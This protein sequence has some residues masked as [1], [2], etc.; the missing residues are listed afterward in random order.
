VSARRSS[1]PRRSIDPDRAHAWRLERQLLGPRR[2]DGPEAVAHALVGVQAQVTSSAALSIALRSGGP[3]ARRGR[4]G[5]V[6]AALRDRRLVRSWAMRSTLHL[7]A[8]EDVPIVAAALGNPERWRRPK[9]L[10]WL[11]MTEPELEACMETID[12]VLDDGRPRTRA[13]LSAEVGDRLGP[14]AARFLLGSWGAALKFASDRSYLV[15]SSADEAGVRFVKAAH[16]VPWR[17][18][19]QGDAMAVIIERYLAAYGPATF[20]ELTRWWG[21]A[22]QAELRPILESLGDRVS[23]VDVDGVPA[24]LRTVD[25]E[26]LEATRPTRGRI[27]LLGGFDPLIVG[28]GLRNQL[29][30]P[31]HLKRISRTAGWISPVVLRDGRAIGVWDA[32][33]AGGR[34][35]ITVDAFDVL[36][37]AERARIAAA[38]EPVA[39]AQGLV[40]EVQYGPVF[41][42]KGAALQ[43]GPDDS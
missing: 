32:T 41:T 21:A 29:L 33:R 23:G 36:T 3:G 15:Q 37:G 22:T 13:E 16:W 40:A 11:G 17:Q 5:A 19:D 7:F 28:A 12:R 35:R 4:V 27:T 26:A 43:I 1:P 8:A 14:R 9:W 30:P 42:T 34:L 6:T 2:A 25:V 10:I 31:R 39:A 18:V 20:Q 38:A 24:L